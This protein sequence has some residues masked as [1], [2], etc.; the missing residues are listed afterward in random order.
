MK[1][2]YS[3]GVS[4]VMSFI[5]AYGYF[6]LPPFLFCVG[7]E[8]VLIDKTESINL[9]LKQIYYFDI[10]LRLQLRM[11]YELYTIIDSYPRQFIYWRVQN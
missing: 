2:R 11:L 8:L 9:D 7:N 1:N 4:G 5:R 3:L 6:F 10:V